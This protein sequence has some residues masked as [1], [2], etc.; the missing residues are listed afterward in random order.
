MPKYWGTL[1]IIVSVSP[2]TSRS[3]HYH[4]IP[5]LNGQTLE[6]IQMSWRVIQTHFE[7][8]HYCN[9]N[10]NLF[11]ILA[12]SCDFAIHPAAGQSTVFGDSNICLLTSDRLQLVPHLTTQ[13][14]P[15]LRPRGGR[16]HL[17]S[18]LAS[19]NGERIPQL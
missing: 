5:G 15:G 14:Q 13:R 18:L 19:L 3:L 12:D 10:I 1:A 7:S 9:H 11:N 17:R 4:L 8:I 16:S 2:Q 6:I